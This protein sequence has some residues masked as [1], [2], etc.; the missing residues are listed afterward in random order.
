MSRALKVEGQPQVPANA[1]PLFVIKILSGPDQGIAHPLNKEKILIGR[2]EEN[3]I[4]L[5]DPRVSR[6]H[7]S[8]RMTQQGLYVKDSG[9]ST[10]LLINGRVTK[11]SLI[12]PGTILTI[13]DTQLKFDVSLHTAVASTQVESLKQASLNDVSPFD[14]VVKKPKENKL[15]F[16]LVLIG[17]IGGGAYLANR[18]DSLKKQ[19]TAIRTEEIV[20][21]EIE[22]TRKRVED[23]FRLQNEK[24]KNTQQYK[25][26]QSSFIKGFRDFNAGQFK[27][28]MISF[29]AARALYP[30]HELAT[31]YYQLSE[32]KL[33][34]IINITLTEAKRAFE[35]NQFTLAGSKYK[36][37]MA[38]VEDVNDKRYI[39]AKERYNEVQLIIK[40]SF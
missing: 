17:I 4:T 8:I 33:S 3:D 11:E 5:N 20:E 40:G 26:A 34:Q 7:A 27:R 22:S 28:A 2:G 32:V 1:L 39:E 24:G 29:S 37:V 14:S 9:S 12:T 15:P 10:G 21:Q 25:D 36:Q 35:L 19:S 38:L 31:K 30:D 18:E 13:G 6:Q 23:L 16:Y